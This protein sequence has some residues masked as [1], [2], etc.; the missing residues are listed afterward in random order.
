MNYSISEQQHPIHS[1][2]DFSNTAEEVMKGIDLTNKIAI[3]TGG[4]SGI[5][6]ENVRLLHAAGATVIVPT[7]NLEATQLLFKDYTDR[8]E[9]VY[10]D[11]IKPASI[12]DFAAQFLSS[13]RPIHLLINN[14]GIM[15]SPLARDERG[16]ESQFATNHLGHYQLTV[17]LWNALK[18]ANGARVVNVSSLGHRFSDIIYD[19]PNFTKTPYDRWI[20]YGQSKT[21]NIL[22]SVQLDAIGKDQGIRSY[23]VHPGRIMDTNL[24]KYLSHEELIKLNAINEDGSLKNEMEATLKTIAQGA[25]TTLFC[26][27][28]PLLNG[29]G[30]VHCEDNDIARVVETPA[31]GSQMSN[32]VLGYAIDRNNAQRLW[33][34]SEKLTDVTISA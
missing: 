29:I 17:R 15:A 3:V 26:A 19:D 1:G 23:S 24:K 16:Y 9:L 31:A 25:A 12:D 11:L 5:G 30:G 28:S 2:Y 7:R 13:G 27:T 14:A 21:A 34:L 20:A 22:F 8:L 6:Q 10:M 4:Y 33:A 32:G 18:Q